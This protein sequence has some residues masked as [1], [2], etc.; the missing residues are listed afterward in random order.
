VADSSI[1]TSGIGPNR[2]AL[3]WRDSSYTNIGGGYQL[4]DSLRVSAGVSRSTNSVPDSA[5][6][7]ALPDMDRS[8]FATGVSWRLNRAFLSLRL[9]FDPEQ[10]RTLTTQPANAFGELANGLLRSQYL[11]VATGLNWSF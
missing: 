10:M 11:G 3:R 4:N 8:I 2:C 9:E 5:F 6:T 1:H 7:P